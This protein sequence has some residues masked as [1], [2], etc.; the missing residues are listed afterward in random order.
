MKDTYRYK[1]DFY[2]NA[3]VIGVFY[4]NLRCFENSRRNLS[5]NLNDEPMS[6]PIRFNV[7]REA[8]IFP[9]SV[10]LFFSRTQG[11][12]FPFNS[13]RMRKIRRYNGC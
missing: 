2:G 11:T 10:L 13:I 8:V 4:R 1:K 6:L 12:L 7:D 3:K 5:T 9:K